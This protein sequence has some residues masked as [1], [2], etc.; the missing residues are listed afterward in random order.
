M[1]SIDTPVWNNQQ[2]NPVNSGDFEHAEFCWERNPS[3]SAV[4]Q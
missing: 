2:Y 3:V 1:M 4:Y